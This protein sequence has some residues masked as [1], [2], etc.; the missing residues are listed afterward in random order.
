MC[1][2][3][4]NRLY[5][6]LRAVLLGNSFCLNVRCSF[7]RIEDKM[8][9]RDSSEDAVRVWATGIDYVI[10]DEVAYPDENGTMYTCQ[11]AHTSQTGWEPPAVPALWTAQDASGDDNDGLPNEEGQIEEA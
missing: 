5:E 3:P 6:C 8:C 11:Q 4:R 9:I 7:V 1:R 2:S 10:G